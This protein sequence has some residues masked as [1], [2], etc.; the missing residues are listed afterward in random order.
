MKISILDQRHPEYDADEMA[1]NRALYRGGKSVKALLDTLLPKGAEEPEKRYEVRK[2][3]AYY[4][5]HCAGVVDQLVAEL[6]AEHPAIESDPENPDKFW[7]EFNGDC[8]LEKHSLHQYQAGRFREAFITG[9]AWTLCTLPKPKKGEDG[10]PV[11]FTDRAAE[12]ASG[13]RRAYLIAL[14]TEAVIDWEYDEDGELVWAVVKDE[15]TPRT[16]PDEER[17]LKVFTWTVYT[18]KGGPATSGSRRRRARRGRRTWRRP[19]STR[20][21]TPSA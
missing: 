9:R 19:R 11:S 8:D 5:N 15:R 21:R 10:K 16:A 14:P 3:L 17:V 6:F 4:V 20:G 13:Q 2:K 7:K 1:I 12:D 18:P